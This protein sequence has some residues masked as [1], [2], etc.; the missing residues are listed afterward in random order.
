MALTLTAPLAY[1]ANPG[2]VQGIA[3]KG[4][5][6]IRV[7]ADGRSVRVLPLASGK[8]A[9]LL[10]PIGLPPRDI[11]VKVE[12]LDGKRVIAL[13]TVENVFGLPAAAAAVAPPQTID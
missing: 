3:P 7:R 8:R 5:T 6:A 12:A 2:I 10:G 11:T 1:E 9:F 4:T 13:A